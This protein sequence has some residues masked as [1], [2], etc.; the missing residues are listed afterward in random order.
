MMTDKKKFPTGKTGKILTYMMTHPYITNADAV[1]EFQ[2][3]RLSSHIEMLRHNWG[4][5]I[6]TVMVD[7]EDSKYGR[8][9]LRRE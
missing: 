4:Y 1:R 3:Y 5:D 9:Y 8:Y 2:A 7:G 6:E